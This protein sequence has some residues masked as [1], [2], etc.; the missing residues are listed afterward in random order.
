MLRK[1][2]C[3][4]W[5][6]RC[7]LSPTRRFSTFLDSYFVPQILILLSCCNNSSE[8]LPVVILYTFCTKEIRHWRCGNFVALPWNISKSCLLQLC[9]PDVCMVSCATELRTKPTKRN[10]TP[11]QDTPCKSLRKQAQEERT[12]YETLQAQTTTTSSHFQKKIK[13]TAAPQT[14]WAAG[15]M[16]TKTYAESRRSVP[17]RSK[18]PNRQTDWIPYTQA[19]L[20]HVEPTSPDS[21]FFEHHQVAINWHALQNVLLSSKFTN[22]KRQSTLTYLAVPSAFEQWLSRSHPDSHLLGACPAEPGRLVSTSLH[23]WRQSHPLPQQSP[24][25]A[26]TRSRYSRSMLPPLRRTPAQADGGVHDNRAPIVSQ[27]QPSSAP[28]WPLASLGI[29]HFLW[30]I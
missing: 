3:R 4:H 27:L 20:F 10:S 16:M 1:H 13:L 29:F 11:E 24:P 25:T 21:T 7:A 26:C 30:G 2:K 28:L 14:H 15:T 17:P 8:L 23:F 18:Q 9:S 6:S 12:S 22:N 5:H 19:S